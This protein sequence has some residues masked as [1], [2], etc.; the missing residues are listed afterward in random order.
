MRKVICG[1]LVAVLLLSVT[2]L[3][4]GT[5][6]ADQKNVS[7]SASIAQSDNKFSM[8][9][10]DKVNTFRYGKGAIGSFLFSVK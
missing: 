2:V 9:S 5:A 7:V 4:S 6:F 8:S 10:S 1:F 3:I